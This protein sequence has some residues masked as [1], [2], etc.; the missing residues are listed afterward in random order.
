MYYFEK[1]SCIVFVF[2]LFAGAAMGDLALTFLALERHGDAIATQ[3]RVLHLKQSILPKDHPEI[4]G[5]PFTPC[6]VGLHIHDTSLC[7]MHRHGH[8]QFGE[9]VSC[10]RKAC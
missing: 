8:E 1:C 2:F 3:K 6:P 5:I 10:S 4:G 7:S 9:N